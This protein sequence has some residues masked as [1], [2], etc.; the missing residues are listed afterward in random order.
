M[1]LSSFGFF[2][3]FLMSYWSDFIEGEI[4]EEINK[5]FFRSYAD[6]GGGEHRYESN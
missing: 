3:I 6:I 1:Y 2:S 5:K 4:G